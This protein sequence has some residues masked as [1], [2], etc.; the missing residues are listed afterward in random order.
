[1]KMLAARKDNPADAGNAAR[2]LGYLGDVRG[3]DE[4]LAAYAEDFQPRVMVD[5]IRALGVVA[6]APLIALIEARPALAERRTA[7][8]VLAEMPDRDLAATLIA[9]LEQKPRDAAFPDVASLYLKLAAVHPDCRR[10]VAKA[11]LD[12]H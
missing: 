2:A 5:A 10:A 1:V 6:I 8:D 11:I 7:L 4:L 12:R 9:R 3:V